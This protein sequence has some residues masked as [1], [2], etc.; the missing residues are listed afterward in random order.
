MSTINEIENYSLCIPRVSNNVTHKDIYGAFLK[1]DLGVLKR[2]DL[3][4]RKND[5]GEVS[6]RAFVHFKYWYKNENT[7]F[8]QTR[9]NEGKDI[10]VVY[11]DPWYWKVSL[12]K[13]SRGR[14]V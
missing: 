13:S 9:L 7:L 11:D 5:K 12:N 14:V 10:K 1:L 4:E 6:K 3:I 8:V 2:V